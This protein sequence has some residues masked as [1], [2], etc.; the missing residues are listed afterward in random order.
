MSNDDIPPGMDTDE[1]PRLATMGETALRTALLAARDE[2]PD[3]R[4][5][6][7]M[8]AKLSAAGAGAGAEGAA[9]TVAGALKSKALIGVVLVSA[10]IGV[11]GALYLRRQPPPRPA[12]VAEPVRPIIEPIAAP[13]R[14]SDVAPSSLKARPARRS[15]V[16][17]RGFVPAPPAPAAADPATI[18]EEARLLD[19][20]RSALAT[21]PGQALERVAEHGRRFPSGLLVQEREVIAIEA[22]VKTGQRDA[23]RARTQAFERSFPRSAHLR[24]LQTLLGPR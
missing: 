23:A 22:L 24:R 12:A 6:A 5:L 15:P 2:R 14:A 7:L 8:G 10:G 13:E 1:P 16:R 17:P 11:G 21:A 3:E 4:R 20:A 18:A 9:A 19:A